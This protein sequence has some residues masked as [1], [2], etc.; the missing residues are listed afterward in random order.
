MLDWHNES[1]SNKFLYLLFDLLLHVWMEIS[2]CVFY[3]LT[4]S[5]SV[6][7]MTNHIYVQSLHV[8]VTPCKHIVIL[9]NPFFSFLDKLRF[10]AIHFCMFYL[11]LRF[12]SSN[13]S[14]TAVESSCMHL[15][16][17]DTFS[18]IIFN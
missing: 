14:L 17:S 18:S 6:E 7:C 9:A 8:L 3:W 13:S 11:S 15:G 2:F 12:T 10:I 1:G 16:T 5:V 4:I